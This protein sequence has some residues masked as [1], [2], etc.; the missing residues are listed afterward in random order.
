M[1]SA[2]SQPEITIT[3]R[4]RPER[5]FRPSRHAVAR[6]QSR[7]LSQ[8][9]IRAALAYG[10]RFYARGAEIF[11]IGRKEVAFYA[12][13]GID[14]KDFSGIQVVCSPDG[15]IVTAYRNHDFSRIRKRKYFG[16]RS[17]RM[18]GGEILL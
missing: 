4:D 13:H 14:L 8:Q 18:D 1:D 2:I 12:T 9:A 11:A 3:R 16:G 5:S 7:S 6:M 15:H 17:G 10:R